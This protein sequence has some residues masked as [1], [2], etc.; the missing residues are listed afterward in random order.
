MTK[1]QVHFPRPSDGKKLVTFEWLPIRYRN[2]ISVLKNP[3]PG[4]LTCGRCGRRL[5]VVY[6]GRGQPRPVY[7]C[8]RP[9]LQM[10]A[11]IGREFPL[12]LLSAVWRGSAALGFALVENGW[13]VLFTRTND[14][15]QR[16][17][18][19]VFLLYQKGRE[20]QDRAIDNFPSRP[21]DR[22]QFHVERN[23]RR[24]HLN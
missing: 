9:N 4:L 22:R 5:S 13:R 21:R 10:A 1:D 2:V 14:L 18:R 16:L 7:R 24:Y 17:I 19:G 12:R 20:A 15:V 3:L 6:A 8:D 11:V 23:L